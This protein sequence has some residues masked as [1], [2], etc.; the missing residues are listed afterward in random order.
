MADSRLLRSL[1]DWRVVVGVMGSAISVTALLS[2]LLR[3]GSAVDQYV[4]I[5]AVA[6]LCIFA[7]VYTFTEVRRVLVLENLKRRYT[8]YQTLLRDVEKDVTE[9]TNG[10]TA[11][12]R[13]KS[14][15]LKLVVDFDMAVSEL[16]ALAAHITDDPTHGLTSNLMEY[17]DRERRLYITHVFG[18]YGRWRFHRTFDPSNL[19]TAGSCG[20]AYRER[21]IIFVPDTSESPLMYWEAPFEKQLLKGVINIPLITNEEPKSIIGV[22]N[23]DSPLPGLLTEEDCGPRAGELQHLAT[24]LLEAKS[25]FLA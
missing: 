24:L 17:L 20:Y 14:A 13:S 7:G 4:T 6:V 25:R 8:D 10:V 22:L 19:L 23:I 16:L 12:P 21:R 18:T 11:R 15:R 1:G 9:I 3:Y 5:G 2:T